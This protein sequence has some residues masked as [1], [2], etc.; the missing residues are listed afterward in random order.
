MYKYL[1][2]VNWTFFLL[3]W[4]GW[5]SAQNPSALWQDFSDAKTT[6]AEPV[7]P[8]FSYAGYKNGEAAI[9]DVNHTI[10]NVTDYGAIANDG[11]SD[12]KAIIDAIAA[13]EE[14]GSGIV[15]FPTGKFLVNEPTDNI[16]QR[17]TINTSNI[18]LRGNGS[19]ENGTELFMNSH[20]EPADPA[21]L[22]S[23][24]HLFTIKSNKGNSKLTDITA[25]A[26]RE[27]HSI[28]VASTTGLSVGQ[29]VMLYLQ[30]ND[31]QAVAEA[32]SPYQADATWTNIIDN[33]VSVR[34]IH[35]IESIDGNTIT[36]KEPIHKT[37]NS[38]YNWELWNFVYIEG[39]GVEDIAFTGNFQKDFVH[40]DTFYDDSGWGCLQLMRVVNSWVRN[41]S[42]SSF[43]RCVNIATS[44][45]SSVLNC[46]LSGNPGH[47]GVTI[48]TSSHIL[49]GLSDDNAGFWHSF[50]VA[51]A[52]SGNVFW[53]LSW[54]PETAYESHASQPTCTLFDRIEGGF[55][56]GR[57]G[58][59]VQ[60]QPNHM[61]HLVFWN[62]KN[63][64]ETINNFE[65]WRSTSI[66]GRI[67][68]P[69]ISGFHG[70]TITFK[71]NQVQVNES[72]GQAVDPKSLYEAQLIL[73]L[74]QL[75]DWLIQA[76]IER[77]I[78]EPI[79]G[80][81]KSTVDG[82]TTAYVIYPNPA[83]QLLHI[84]G[85]TEDCS[86]QL[87]S[88]EGRTIEALQKANSIDVSRLDSGVYLVLIKKDKDVRT[89]KFLKK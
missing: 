23:S 88:I 5:L 38:N 68:P 28:Q 20:M 61:R 16:N 45:V 36:F 44:S 75:P 35:K 62:F 49:V 22:Y 42:F 64:G 34:E 58:G 51:N 15:F 53:R 4:C 69:I 32:M 12:K 70:N 60:N 86:V 41:C 31:P 43:S 72:Q 1:L 26:V 27:T 56:Y 7:L 77:G 33:G 6:G 89:L 3:L 18:V 78:E 24:P 66:Y 63:I 79:T 17:I 13:A 73:R 82:S 2:K 74:G 59:A 65:F 14:N 81:S 55:I 37:I 46:Q 30:D 40:H 39:I 11:K 57:W 9:P 10:F 29:Y 50:G 8:D 87:K 83:D 19:G 21:K 25:D 71:E 80:I 84:Q 85:L 76:K 54:T 47:N 48:A 67:L 52:C